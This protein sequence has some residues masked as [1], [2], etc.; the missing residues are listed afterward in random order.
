MILIIVKSCKQYH[1]DANIKKKG[2]GVL[3]LMSECYLKERYL[4]TL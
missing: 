1:Q 4:I 3:T 2:L